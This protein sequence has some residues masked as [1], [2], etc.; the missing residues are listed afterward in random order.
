VVAYFLGPP[1]AY[2]NRQ[3]SAVFQSCMLNIP[4]QPWIRFA[5]VHFIMENMRPRT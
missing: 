5:A 2:I 4:I 3:P 1:V